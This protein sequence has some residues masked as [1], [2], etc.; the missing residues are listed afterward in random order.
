MSYGI[1]TYDAAG[2]LVSEFTTNLMRLIA[3]IRMEASTSGSYATGIEGRF[4]FAFFQS[5]VSSQVV[6]PIISISAAGVVSW[7]P[8]PNYQQFHRAGYILVL[9]QS[10]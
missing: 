3:R 4:L 1:R 10:G 2:N 6:H 9:S 7:S 8:Y 5:D